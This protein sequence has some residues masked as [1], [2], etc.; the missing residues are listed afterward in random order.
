[1]TPIDDQGERADHNKLTGIASQP[2]GS[3][4][5]ISASSPS[6]AV[7]LF[8]APLNQIVVGHERASR[9]APGAANRSAWSP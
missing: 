1:M 7:N 5:A 2:A 8:G 6:R 3:H 4:G 9:T